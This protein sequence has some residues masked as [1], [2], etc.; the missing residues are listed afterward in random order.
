MTDDVGFFDWA[1]K[2]LVTVLFTVGGWLW[3]MLVGKVK[4]HDSELRKVD[5][6]LG[7]HKLYSAQTYTT[8]TDSN[9]QYDEL[10]KKIDRVIDMLAGINHPGP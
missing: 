6:E 4:E 10:A 3:L 7:E 9:R 2:G 5:G 8:K 1:F